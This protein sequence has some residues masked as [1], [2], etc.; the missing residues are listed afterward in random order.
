MKFLRNNM[1]LFFSFIAIFFSYFDYCEAASLSVTITSSSSSVV[2][3]NTITYTVKVSSSSLLGVINYKFNYDSS[4]LTL[5]SGT[6]NSAIAFKG[7][8]KSATYTF[9]FKAKASGT[10]NVSFV[11]N[12]ALDWDG[13]SFSFNKTTSRSTKII[14]QQQLENSYSKNN[15]LSSLSVSNYAIT[16]NF[17][18]NVLEY[19]L[20]LENNIRNINIT[21]SKEDSKSSVSGLGS[22]ALEEGNNKI[23]IKVTAQNGSTRIYTINV[24]VKE[25]TPII[26]ELEGKSLNVVRK[27]DLLQSPNSQYTETTI[28]I[29]EEAVPAFVNEVTKVTLIGLKDS[30]GNIALYAYEDGKY[31]LYKEFASN[32]TLLTILDIPDEQLNKYNYKLTTIVINDN[33]VKA[34]QNEEVKNSY[35]VYATNIETGDD[36]YYTYNSIDGT[37]QLYDDYR[38]VKIKNLE[39]EK[40]IWEYIIMGL[41]IFLVITYTFILISAIKKSIKFKKKKKEKVLLRNEENIFEEKPN[42]NELNDVDDSDLDIL[43]NIEENDSFDIKDIDKDNKNEVNNSNRKKKSKKK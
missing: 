21:G 7:T 11:I 32:K 31:T 15:Y 13:N 9:K 17:N 42:K 38:D 26:V 3:G 37:F 20:T 33:E 6:L 22:H 30:S 16:P 41:G 12:E 5:V 14:T 23:E 28:L 4:K 1:M 8:E 35:L 34:L 10:A 39:K 2:V 29:N 36:N 18:K 19:S 24:T 43:E 40:E 27:K 25:L